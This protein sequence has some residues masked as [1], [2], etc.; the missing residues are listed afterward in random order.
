MSLVGRQSPQATR[1]LNILWVTLGTPTRRCFLL[2]QHFLTESLH[3]LT[4]LT[5]ILTFTGFTSLTPGPEAA[6]LPALIRLRSRSGADQTSQ[7]EKDGFHS[8]FN[9]GGCGD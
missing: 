9:R 8:W 7:K 2:P 1:A 6:P 4:A 5:K 3:A